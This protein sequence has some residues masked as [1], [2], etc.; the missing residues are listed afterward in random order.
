MPSCSTCADTLVIHT[1]RPGATSLR[2]CP[3]CDPGGLR[4]FARDTVLDPEADALCEAEWMAQQQPSGGGD[5][6]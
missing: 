4:L 6:A 3:A 2:P 5:D 1:D